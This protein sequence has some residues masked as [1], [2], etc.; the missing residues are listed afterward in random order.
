MGTHI[1]TVEPPSAL[2]LLLFCSI[3]LKSKVCYCK[4]LRCVLQKEPI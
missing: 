3:V 4:E 1:Y 2:W